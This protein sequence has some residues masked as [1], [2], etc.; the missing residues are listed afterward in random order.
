MPDK[1]ADMKRNVDKAKRPP[2]PGDDRLP[3]G[4]VS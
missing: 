2:S 3:E 1:G 4:A